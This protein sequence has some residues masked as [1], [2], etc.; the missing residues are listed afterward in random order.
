[1]IFAKSAWIDRTSLWNNLFD[2][3]RHKKKANNVGSRLKQYLER[4]K[5]KLIYNMLLIALFM[6]VSHCESRKNTKGERRMKWKFLKIHKPSRHSIFF[7]IKRK[8]VDS[9]CYKRHRDANVNKN[10]T[11]SSLNQKRVFYL[12]E[13]YRTEQSFYCF[14]NIVIQMYEAISALV[15]WKYK[16]NTFRL[17]TFVYY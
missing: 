1:M 7:L 10:T 12:T 15:V 8:I 6:W 4:I 5:M 14:V 13:R 17:A 16:A 3:Q 11:P 2:Q 9:E